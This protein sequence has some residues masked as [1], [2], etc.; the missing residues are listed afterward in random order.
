M[1]ICV[2]HQ[3]DIRSWHPAAAAVVLLTILGCSGGPSAVPLPDFDPESA[4]ETAM[5]LYDV[6]GDGFVAG[7]ELENAPGLKSAIKNLDADGDGKVSA[8]DVAERV[9]TW[10]D[11]RIGLMSVNIQVEM[12][13]RP[14]TGAEVTFEPEEFMGGAIETAYGRTGLAGTTSIK[15]PKERRPS[16]DS[17][18]GVQ[19][20][21]YKVKISK[22][23]GGQETI[24]AKYN[25]E[26]TLGQQVSKDDWAISNK[27]VIFRLKSK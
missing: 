11:M 12:D 6:D 22:I 20:G 10:Q 21:M 13:G 23:E 9:R 7:E 26:T 25:T 2:S 24:P 15:V 5:E 8:E 1:S 27:Q 14:L 18:P 17:P 16:P 4:A 3:R 19:A